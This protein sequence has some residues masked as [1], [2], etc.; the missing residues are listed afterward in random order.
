M[1]MGETKSKA[2]SSFFC[3]TWSTKKIGR[4]GVKRGEAPLNTYCLL[5][6]ILAVLLHFVSSPHCKHPEF[7]FEDRGVNAKIAE[8]VRFLS[9]M[10]VDCLM[11]RFGLLFSCL[12]A[13]SL[14]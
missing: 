2:K 12:S 14:N 10:K 7:L 11:Q 9:N 6:D 1:N 3:P 5:Q 4:T 8:V 13:S